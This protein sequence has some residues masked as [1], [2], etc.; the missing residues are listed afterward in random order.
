MSISEWFGVGVGICAAL[1]WWRWCIR[2]AI[3]DLS[4]KPPNPVGVFGGTAMFLFSWLWVPIYAICVG[5]ARAANS[6]VL[7]EKVFPK[8]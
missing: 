8:L 1:W 2:K 5:G 6:K 7:T 3:W 4:D